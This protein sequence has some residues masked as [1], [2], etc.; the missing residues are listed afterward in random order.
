MKQKVALKGRKNLE[1][2]NGQFNDIVSA[3]EIKN[4]CR[5]LI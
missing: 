5:A 3:G 4:Y 1:Q 2:I